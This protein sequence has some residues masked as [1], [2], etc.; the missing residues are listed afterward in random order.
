MWY[1]ALI[2]KKFGIFL[3]ILSVSSIIAINSSIAYDLGDTHIMNLKKNSNDSEKIPVIVIL[4]DNLGMNTAIKDRK[5]PISKIQDNVLKNLNADEFELRYRYSAINGFSGVVTR[6]G[7]EK[8]LNNPL[9]KGVYADRERYLFLQDSVPLINATNVWSLQINGINLTGRGETICIIDTGVDYTHPDLGGCNIGNV[10]YHGSVGNLTTPVETPHP[11]PNNTVLEYKIN[12][13]DAN[14]TG[15]EIAIH[16]KNISTESNYDFVKVYDENGTIIAIYSGNHEDLWTPS[17]GGDTM[18]IILESDPY[19]D[20]YGFYIDKV[21]NGSVNITANWSDCRK[22]VYGWDIYNGDPDPM[23][24]HGHGTHCAGIAAANGSVKGVAP[25]AKIVAVKV[26]PASGFTTD[27]NIIAG[28]D[29]CVNISEIYNVSVISMSLGGGLYSSYCDSDE[30]AFSTAINTAVA[31]NISVVVASGNDY[32]TSGISAPACIENATPVGATDKSDVMASFTNRGSGFPEMLLAPGVS[33]NSTIPGGYGAWSG[34]SMATPHVAGAIALIR[35]YLRLTNREKTPREIEKLLNETGKRIYDSG[36]GMYF[37]RIDV[38]S[39]ILSLNTTP[40]VVL[41]SPRNFSF[42]NK[43]YSILNWTCFDPDGENMSCY[44]YGDNSS[45]ETLLYRGNCSNNV[46]HTYNWTGLNETIYYWRVRCDD[47][48]ASKF[49]ETLTFGVDFTSPIVNF[50]FPT[51]GN[52]SVMDS[53]SFVINISHIEK[54][55]DKLVLNLNNSIE[56]YNYSGNYTE[57]KITRSNGVYSY[58][59]WINDSAGN[60]NSTE[61]RNIVINATPPTV[62]LISPENNSFS[63]GDV[64]LSCSATDNVQLSSICLF[65]NYSGVWN[66]S[67][68]RDVSGVS[69]FTIFERTNLSDKTFIWNCMACDNSSNCAFYSENLSVCID[70]IPPN[71]TFYSITPVVAVNGTNVS[72]VVNATDLHLDRVWADI[73]LPSGSSERISPPQNFTVNQTG[74]YNITFFANDSAGNMAYGEYYFISEVGMQFNL[75]ATGYNDT[76]LN[77]T[78]EIYF[79][80]SLIASNRSVGN[81]SLII[82]RYRYNLKFSVFNNSLVASFNDVNVSEDNNKTVR[83]DRL[84][85]TEYLVVYAISSNYSMSNATL[86]LSYNGTDFTSESHLDVY[87]CPEWNFSSRGCD[88]NWTNITENITQDF[89]NDLFIINVHRFSG[90]AIKQEGFCGDGVKNDGEEC[91]G[92]DFG[93]KTCVSFGYDYGSLSCT[94]DCKISRSGCENR[95]FSGYISSGGGGGSSYVSKPKPSCFDGIQNCHHGSC[96]E[97]IDCGGPCRPCPSCFDGIQNQGEEGVDCGGPCEPCIT[98]TTSTITITTIPTPTTTT[99]VV[100]LT[101]I[102]ETTSS[103]ETTTVMSE[104]SR[105]IFYAMILIVVSVVMIIA[106]LILRMRRGGKEITEGLEEDM[107]KLRSMITHEEE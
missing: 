2:R 54:N 59:V 67:E 45:A 93:G 70:T 1:L 68:C 25:D 100:A 102:K 11:Y 82:P 13:S 80:G 98:T 60:S 107:Y 5:L 64:N 43:N 96:E 106:A 76:P 22:V 28:I 50:T 65:W 63:N 69:N 41:N 84:N 24:D 83:F 51:P 88:G 42:T 95:K 72:I 12:L 90:F 57:I 14:L 4:R 40:I 104:E 86:N 79:D 53:N 48:L 46:S 105:D 55:P 27:S 71:M 17:G 52:N 29:F 97:G 101:T 87:I 78:I 21:I 92:N 34:T 81:L 49:S 73:T 23:D 75:S 38:Y 8:L 61:I 37:S 32:N 58:Y 19:V 103:V 31:H 91:D 35:Q 3:I 10:V 26:F 16:F 7:M 85:T 89:D 74:R 62:T 33:I 47:N 94:S 44:V 6:K 20:G 56:I 66:L 39:A 36:T 9:V 77:I 99:T 30:S 18:Y 15:N